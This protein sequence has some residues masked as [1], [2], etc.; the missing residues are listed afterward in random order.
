[1][2]LQTVFGA[3][4]LLRRVSRVVK[5]L[6]NP[7]QELGLQQ[8][9]FLSS[10]IQKYSNPR[11]LQASL[12]YLSLKQAHIDAAICLG[13]YHW[14]RMPNPNGMFRDLPGAIAP[15]NEH[16][17]PLHSINISYHSIIELIP[18]ISAYVTPRFFCS[19]LNSPHY[20]KI[21]T[22]CDGVFL[23]IFRFS[24]PVFR[25]DF[26]V[27]RISSASMYKYAEL[28]SKFS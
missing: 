22:T 17:F 18:R 10:W 19:S 2:Q 14:A 28:Y 9:D 16:F 27:T 8:V 6:A 20:T 1:M 23:L 3:H 12:S 11:G 4:S 25:T 21:H 5:P 13:Q 24:F 7:I 15:Y 26:L